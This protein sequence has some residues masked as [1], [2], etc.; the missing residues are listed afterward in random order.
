MEI[1]TDIR[2]E[3]GA[4]Q[5]SHTVLAPHH[6][7]PGSGMEILDSVV[8]AQHSSSQWNLC[9]K[10][11]I[12]FNA[13]QNVK[14]QLAC[15]IAGCS[16]VHQANFGST[17]LTP[18]LL[19]DVWQRWMLIS[20]RFLDIACLH[21]AM[22]TPTIAR[23]CYMKPL[24]APSAESVSSGLARPD[25]QSHITPTCTATPVPYPVQFASCCV[26]RVLSTER[27]VKM[28]YSDTEESD[29]ELEEDEEEKLQKEIVNAC[30]YG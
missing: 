13:H 18:W 20:L 7:I 6:C 15:S 25:R 17:C 16:G 27:S 8:S 30:K 1:R 10:E 2:L 29:V 23:P 12:P 5:I 22:L 11:Y 3:T 24:R 9:R 14:Q 19:W 26:L 4:Y 21:A 28:S